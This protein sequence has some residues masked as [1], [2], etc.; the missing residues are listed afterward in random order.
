MPHHNCGPSYA[1]VQRCET[2][3][4]DVNTKISQNEELQ[5]LYPNDPEIKKRLNELYKLKGMKQKELDDAERRL[6]ECEAQQDK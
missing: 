5:H 6:A 1:A 4:N 3:L 2:A